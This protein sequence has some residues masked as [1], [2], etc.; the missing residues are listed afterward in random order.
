[1]GR[2]ARTNDLESERVFLLSRG[3]E[4]L[5]LPWNKVWLSL[6]LPQ[7]LYSLMRSHSSF[8]YAIFTAECSL[9]TPEERTYLHLKR[10]RN[11]DEYFTFVCARSNVC[12][13]ESSGEDMSS[14]SEI[15]DGGSCGLGS[16]HVPFT[17][18][19]MG[20]FLHIAKNTASDLC[21]IWP[22]SYCSLK[23][24]FKNNSGSVYEFAKTSSLSK[25]WSRM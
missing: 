10:S 17:H 19:E 13:F 14:L 3:W 9:M 25:R 21:G 22:I 23:N 2:P 6:F 8:S 18:I 7:T 11:D 4:P 20:V 24:S 5:D 1:M 16:E 12:V 15:Q